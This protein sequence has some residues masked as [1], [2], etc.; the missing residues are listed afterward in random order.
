MCSYLCYNCCI[1][2]LFSTSQSSEPVIKNKKD[3]TAKRI[4]NR[5][6]QKFDV[7]QSSIESDLSAPQTST[8][9]NLECKTTENGGKVRREMKAVA[10]TPQTKRGNV[11]KETVSESETKTETEPSKKPK[12]RP[13][14]TVVRSKKALN[15]KTTPKQTSR[16]VRRKVAAKKFDELPKDASLPK[17]DLKLVKDALIIKQST[18][19]KNKL[20]QTKTVEKSPS[21]LVSLLLFID[22]KENR[23]TKDVE[24]R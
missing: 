5:R 2:L 15:L 14:R 9:G 11:S 10:L 17:D 19:R 12:S 24:R 7:V 6:K 3:D 18:P 16:P 22:Y 13:V 21:R 20:I 1:Y 8:D 23:S 4:Q